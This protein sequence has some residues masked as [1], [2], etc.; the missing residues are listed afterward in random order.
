V[1]CEEQNGLFGLFVL[2]HVAII[3]LNARSNNGL[4]GFFVP[5]Y[6]EKLQVV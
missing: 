1:G 5:H 3:E 6:I 2:R 4:F